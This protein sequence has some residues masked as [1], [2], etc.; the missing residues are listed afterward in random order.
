MLLLTV[1]FLA[2]LFLLSY[3]FF[4]RDILAPPTVVSLGFLFATLCC[5]YNEKKWMLDFSGT[6][7]W[8]IVIGIACFIGGG[9]I[10]VFLINIFRGGKLGFTHNMSEVHP[11][12]ISVFKTWI[13]VLFELFTL[14]LLFIELR[15]LTGS[16]VWFQIVS[17]FRAQTAHV[18]PEEYTMRLSGICRRSID[19]SFAFALIYAYI[20]GNNIAAKFKQPIINWGPIVLSCILSFMQG[21][22]SDMLRLW[23]AI[24]VVS[25]TLNRRKVGW[26]SSRETKKMVRMMAL[27]VLGIAIV[28]VAL[29]GTVGRS[30]TDW[31][32]IYYLA[33]YA[34]SPIAAFDMFLKNP[35][36][37]SDIWGKETFYNLNQSIGAWF[38]KP[39]LRY[40]FYKEFRRSPS[41][42]WI[43]NVYTAL[44]PA[45]Y[46][47]GFAGM[48]IVMLGMGFFFTFFYLKVRDRRGSNPIDLRLL[49]YSY[50]A[51]TFFLYF[52]NCYNTFVSFGFILI[53]VEFLAAR[54]FLISF[55]LQGRTKRIRFV[56][57]RKR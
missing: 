39:E 26:K 46:D 8:T 55:K 36:A 32:P 3:A 44:R 18:N 38:N 27:S 21:Y 13:V 2:V 4:D 31:D 23:I 20:I 7:T 47:F 16:V 15:R 54:W 57:L 10:A 22:R 49:I 37:P 1:F 28:F 41:G 45:Y 56:S 42:I 43:G 29:R 34:G 6:T 40:I 52:Y 12:E 48:I 53:I 50:V 33:F 5:F 35:L 19:L 9:I 25:F 17:T 14:V 11:I 51:Y 30:E 24:L